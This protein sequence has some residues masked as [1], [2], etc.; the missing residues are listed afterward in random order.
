MISLSQNPQLN[1]MC[2]DPLS[3]EGHTE[4]FQGL[5][6]GHISWGLACGGGVTSIYHRNIGL[7][8]AQQGERPVLG[9]LG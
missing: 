9:N 2:K 1:H 5:G 4:R 8:L 6:C 7:D 3:Q